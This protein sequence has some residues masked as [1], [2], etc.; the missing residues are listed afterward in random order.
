[1]EKLNFSIVVILKDETDVYCMLV[2]MIVSLLLNVSSDSIV[3]SLPLL[4]H[5]IYLA[6]KANCHQ[7]N[8]INEGFL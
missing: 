6:F 4:H 8:M 5:T 7:C 1:M 2:E 3:T